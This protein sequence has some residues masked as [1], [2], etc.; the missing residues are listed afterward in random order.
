[1][2]GQSSYCRNLESGSFAYTGI[3]GWCALRRWLDGRAS[4]YCRNPQVVVRLSVYWH[5]VSISML[6]TLWGRAS[7]HAIELWASWPLLKAYP[8]T[9]W[10]L[11]WPPQQGCDPLAPCFLR[12]PYP[13]S[14]PA[15]RWARHPSSSSTASRISITTMAS[16][17]AGN[18]ARRCNRGSN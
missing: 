7:P 10:P 18:L 16:G 1:M 12:H 2:A 9:A 15:P 3:L 17:P 6:P 14:Q 4:S 11:I 8:C 13:L 5:R